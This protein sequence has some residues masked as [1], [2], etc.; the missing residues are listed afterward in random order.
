MEQSY[1]THSESTV[2]LRWVGLPLWAQMGV[3]FSGLLAGSIA[4]LLWL[5]ESKTGLQG[6]LMICSQIEFSGPVSGNID[7][8]CLLLCPWTS[9]TILMGSSEGLEPG[10]MAASRSS[11]VQRLID[12]PPE[13]QTSMSPTRFLGEQDCSWTATSRGW[14]QV[15]GPLQES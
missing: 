5:I 14:S 13:A 3:Y 4:F 7:W 2:S 9:R 12:L 1:K 8:V 11:I 10:Y 6:C 15:M